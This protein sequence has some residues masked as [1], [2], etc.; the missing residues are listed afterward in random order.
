M[1][2]VVA[3]V[4]EEE[5]CWWGRHKVSL[6]LPPSTQYLS[7]THSHTQQQDP[8][9]GTHEGIFPRECVAIIKGDIEKLPWRSVEEEEEEEEGGEE[10][11]EDDGELQEVEED[12]EVYP[13]LED[14]FELISSLLDSYA[15]SAAVVISKD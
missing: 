8:K 3:R 7:L 12:G 10:D 6:T 1:I 5:T 11:I 13:F 4:T 14:Y 2:I 9:F 15:K